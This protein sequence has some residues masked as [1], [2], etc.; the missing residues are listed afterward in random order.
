MVTFPRER[1]LSRGQNAMAQKVPT[2]HRKSPVRHGRSSQELREPFRPGE[3]E[4]LGGLA[5]SSKHDERMVKALYN[6]TEWITLGY[7]QGK[8]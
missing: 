2:V 8:S 4:I 7:L 1:M 5:V 6:V 3:S